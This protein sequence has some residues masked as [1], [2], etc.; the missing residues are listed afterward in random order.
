[1]YITHLFLNQLYKK[2]VKLLNCLI[3]A[4]NNQKNIELCEF[5]YKKY[6]TLISIISCF[7]LIFLTFFIV[8]KMDSTLQEVGIIHFITMKHSNKF[9]TL[10]MLIKFLISLLFMSLILLYLLNLRTFL[11]SSSSSNS[12]ITSGITYISSRITDFKLTH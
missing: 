6:P 4:Q 3:K 12:L 1:M 10:V 5:I 11:T 9:R 8:E 7:I 2:G